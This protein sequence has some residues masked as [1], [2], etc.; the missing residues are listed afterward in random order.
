[1]IV[2]TVVMSV[3][4]LIP[5]LGWIAMFFLMY[6]L[7]IYIMAPSTSIVSAFK[8]SFSTVKD[9]LL[10]SLVAAIVFLLL[11]FAGSF[12]VILWIITYPIALIMLASVLKQLRPDMS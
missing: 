2:W 10:V 3:L 11:V 6:A 12:L 4:M 9:N 5:I 8:E 7:L 1:M